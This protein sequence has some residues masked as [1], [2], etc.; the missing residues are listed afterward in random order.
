MNDIDNLYKIYYDKYLSI[1]N[2]SK[3]RIPL[4]GLIN[5]NELLFVGQNPGAPFKK[6]HH[7]QF[8]N[9]TSLSYNEQQAL[10][11]SS[12]VQ[13]LFIKFIIK[14]CD[15][16]DIDFNKNVSVTNI[17]KYWTANNARPLVT[18]DDKKLLACEIKIINP[19][20][21]IFLSR[22]AYTNFEHKDKFNIQFLSY[23]HPAAHYYSEKYMKS[24]ANNLRTTLYGKE[25]TEK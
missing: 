11:K 21:V 16:I 13:S 14:I 24:I 5:G 4:M 2:I 7:E 10:F 20:C 18:S 9:F 22:Y 6:E 1:E 12:W 8:S 25:T 3:Y 17:V 23:D 19:K 15:S